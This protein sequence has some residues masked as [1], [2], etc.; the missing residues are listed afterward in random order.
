MAELI[1]L[2]GIVSKNSN[3]LEL[4]MRHEVTVLSELLYQQKKI[5]LAKNTE[6]NWVLF[7]SQSEDLKR[8]AILSLR[9]QADLIKMSIT[10]GDFS[11]L[12]ILRIALRKLKILFDEN[13]FSE[14][15]DT[16]IIEILD[17]NYSQI[18]RSISFFD[19]C[20]YSLLDLVNCPWFDL[21]ERSSAITQQLLQAG[22]RLFSGQTS[23]ISLKDM[24]PYTLRELKT[25]NRVTFLLEEKF[26]AKGKS[27]IDAR[28]YILSVKKARVLNQGL[29]MPNLD[30][31]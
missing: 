19:L 18:Y 22:E 24:E 9:S 20:N 2:D 16:D 5:K 1:N 21:Y 3:Q 23:Y 10:N 15:E 11:E 6:E 17:E 29:G 30:F 26:L 27:A 4:E 13:V 12:A 28:S 25:P 31:I 7:K 8:A 14:V